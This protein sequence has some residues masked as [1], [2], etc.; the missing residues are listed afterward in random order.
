MENAAGDHSQQPPPRLSRKLT[1]PFRTART[2]K[3]SIRDH[4]RQLSTQEL[5]SPAADHVF[6][7]SGQAHEPSLGGEVPRG[8][9][10]VVLGSYAWL[11]VI[12]WIIFGGSVETDLA[13]V[14]VATI[15]VM[16]LAIPVV[17]SR[18]AFN[19]SIHPRFRR[20]RVR[21]THLGTATGELAARE[22]YLQILIIPI[23]LALAATL[24]AIVYLV[25]S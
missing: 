9:Y 15:C 7:V 4:V 25:T 14:V 1:S 10:G 11:L 6:K 13:L 22:A 8:V 5:K 2:E 16:L 23:T 3:P 21:S 18:M 12:A 24:F 20:K 19:H 17:A